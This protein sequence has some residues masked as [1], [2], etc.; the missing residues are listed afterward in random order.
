VAPF[1]PN[2]NGPLQ[3]PAD[4]VKW[5]QGGSVVIGTDFALFMGQETADLRSPAERQGSH[6]GERV[7]DARDFFL[8]RA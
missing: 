3:A 2:P 4:A 1:S 8:Q 7:L 6:S 5:R